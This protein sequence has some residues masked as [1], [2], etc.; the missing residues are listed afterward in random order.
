M[1]FL[2]PS[3]DEIYQLSIDLASRIRAREKVPFD[4]LVGISRGGLVLVRILSDLLDIQDVRIL[5]CE[6]Y[7]DLEKTNK[8]P[9]ISQEL[10]GH[11]NS[12]N[13]LVIDDVADSGK[14]LLA[15]V[16]YLK[17]RRPRVL[18][19]ATLYMKPSTSSPPDFFVKQTSAWIVFPW[20]L[21]ETMKLLSRR[22]LKLS[23]QRLKIPRRYAKAIFDLTQKQ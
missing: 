2:V 4:T 10:Q 21:F 20:E 23:I 13:V 16:D 9:I 19:V 18:K 1:K 15:V 22:K 6:Y 14:S 11:L 7:T 8:R 17:K 5:K 3:W 12:R